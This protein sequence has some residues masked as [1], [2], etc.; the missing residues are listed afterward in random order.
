MSQP[1]LVNLAPNSIE[2][3]K[4]LVGSVLIN[5]DCFEQVVSIVQPRDFFY[6]KHTHI[7]GAMQRLRAQDFP[8]DG[9]LLSEELENHKQL[10]AIGGRA[11]LAELSNSTPTSVHAEFYA[12]L[13]ERAAVRR[14]LMSAADE[15]KAVA[16]DE[17][18]D[19]D[20]VISRAE[21]LVADVS[22]RRPSLVEAGALRDV[23]DL[24]YADIEEFAENGVLMKDILPSTFKAAQWTLEGYAN[25][26]LNTYGARPG[27]G[28][29]S[30]I[31]AEAVGIAQ[32]LRAS[33]DP[34]RVRIY[35]L[36]MTKREVG[37]GIASLFTRIPYKPLRKRQLTEPQTKKYLA[38]VHDLM[39]LPIDVHDRL[40]TLE[41]ILND[42][43]RSWR[44]GTLAI[45]F[46]DYVQLVKT[47]RV[48]KE[49]RLQIGYIT[50]EL[51][52]TAATIQVPINIGAQLR[53]G[54]VGEPTMELLKE[55]GNIEEDSD[56]VTLLHRDKDA[57]K[58]MRPGEVQETTVIIDKNRHG[59]TGRFKI[60]F[61][62]EC[63]G[64]VELAERGYAPDSGGHWSDGR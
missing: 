38:E 13:V 2:A 56:T 33:N 6:L 58:S 5:P 17:A 27:V 14:R 47:Q 62:G 21:S 46:I 50:S 7:W 9:E 10:E 63:K 25:G 36:E 57:A 16:V 54:G 61:L 51:K 26:S 43:Q 4:A 53:R 60:G 19:T 31:V 18:M 34:R 23:I 15:M 35:S 55:A 32:R 40:R 49:K 3:E 42:I 8:I 20:A 59:A 28:K 52:D 1:E 39:R 44:D 45:A 22:S 48:F 37:D 12:Q 24:Q 41:D 29:S 64:F 11:Y 30:L